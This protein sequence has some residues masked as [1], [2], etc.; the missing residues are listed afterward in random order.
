MSYCKICEFFS[1]SFHFNLGLQQACAWSP[2]LFIIYMNWMDHLSQTDE[3]VTIRRC[4]ISW[5]LYADGF[6]FAGL[7]LLASFEYGLQHTLNCF[8]AVCDIAGRKISTSKTQVLHVLKNRVQCS[9]QV[10]KVSLKQVE[11]FKYLEVAF[12]CDGRQ[13]EELDV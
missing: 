6:I 8:A 10:G 12:L 1:K 7:V 3:Y 13:D 9:L 11:K 2:L 4:K 5:L